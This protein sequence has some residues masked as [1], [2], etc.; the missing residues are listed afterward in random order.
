MWGL[1][2]TI[3]SNGR[4]ILW[5]ERFAAEQGSQSVWRVTVY[6]GSNAVLYNDYHV[7]KFADEWARTVREAYRRANATNIFVKKDQIV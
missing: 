5:Q 2:M 1:I 7:E 3:L 4:D 6:A